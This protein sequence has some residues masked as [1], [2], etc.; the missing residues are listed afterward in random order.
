MAFSKIIKSEAILEGKVIVVKTRYNAVAFTR[1]QGEILAF[2]DACTH[3]GEEIACG[4]LEGEIITCPRHFAK[5]NI[6]T[7]AVIA[8]PATEPLPVYK[9]RLVG[10]DVEVDLEE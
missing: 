5:F 10:D 1:I 3:D 6:R 4:K 2:E 8:R 7:G 9:I